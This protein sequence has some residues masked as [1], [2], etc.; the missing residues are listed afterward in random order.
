MVLLFFLQGGW[1]DYHGKCTISKLSPISNTRNLPFLLINSFVVKLQGNVTLSSPMLLILEVVQ[2]WISMLALRSAMV[3]THR[4]QCL[5]DKAMPNR[6]DHLASF[7]FLAY[8]YIE[9]TAIK[10]GND[11][12]EVSGFARKLCAGE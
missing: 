11:I 7:P 6:S 10:I 8:S 5:P 2:V 4:L 1:F 3:S 9:S 12:L